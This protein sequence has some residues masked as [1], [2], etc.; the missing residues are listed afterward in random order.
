MR[1]CGA[2]SK[3][4]PFGSPYFL[5]YFFGSP[6]FPILGLSSCLLDLHLD[7]LSPKQESSYQR[8]Y[9]YVCIYCMYI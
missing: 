2:H 5:F 4:G 8:I 7:F 6:Y 1:E 3:G 9:R